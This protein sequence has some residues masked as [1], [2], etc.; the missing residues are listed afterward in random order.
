MK[1]ELLNSV[2]TSFY[3]CPD[4]DVH[5]MALID[6]LT[7]EED[8]RADLLRLMPNLLDNIQGF[9]SHLSP[10]FEFGN[11]KYENFFPIITKLEKEKSYPKSYRSIKNLGRLL[12]IAALWADY[13]AQITT[14]YKINLTVPVS[15]AHSRYINLKKYLRACELFNCYLLPIEKLHNN[16]IELGFNMHDWN[17]RHFKELS[18]RKTSPNIFINIM[19]MCHTPLSIDPF[20]DEEVKV[21][22]SDKEYFQEFYS[23]P[24][25]RTGIKKAEEWGREKVSKGGLYITFLELVR[26][27]S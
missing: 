14:Y 26:R 5:R 11:D 18:R 27:F 3:E 19:G 15:V 10:V 25:R 7:E 21:I 16:L 8:P 1:N 6:L 24:R 2:V 9:K 12:G 13:Y 4:E 23:L 20:F 22:I 17:Y